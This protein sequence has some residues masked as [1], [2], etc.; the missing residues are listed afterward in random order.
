MSRP[1]TTRD[2]SPAEGAGGPDPAP[3]A[4]DAWFRRWFGPEYLAL[5][6]HRDR[7]EAELG[8]RLFLREADAVPGDRILDLGCGQGRHLEAFRDR[9]LEGVGLD[10]SRPLLR[11]ARAATDG[12]TPL[13]QADMRRVPLAG[14]TFDAVTSFFTSFGYFA[15]RSEDRRV[16]RE[17]RR[18]LRPGGAYLLDFLNA[19]Q[20]RAELVPEEEA[21]VD[22]KTVIQ[23][24]E[25][26]EGHVV[27]RIEIRPGGEEAPKVYHERVR[28]YEPGELVEM[29]GEASLP[30]EARFGDYDG[31]DF[32]STS[33]RFIAVGRA[34]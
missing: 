21:T 5:Y 11:R 4:D 31:S 16:L 33:P 32:E 17:V 9:G 19:E 25:I 2:E 15:S 28:L 27:K 18:V 23:S 14:A 20:V 12:R 34:A 13:V 22:G 29:L 1:L 3:D 24:R 26:R 30:A 10:L 7:E 8:V 6:P